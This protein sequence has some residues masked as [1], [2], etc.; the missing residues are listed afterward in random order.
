MTAAPPDAAPAP[1]GTPHPSPDAAPATRQQLLLAIP[2]LVVGAV[3]A[4]I[5]FGLDELSEWLEGLIWHAFPAATGLDPSNGFFIFTVLTLTGIA[6]GLVV[7]QLPGH[8]GR[9]SATTEL[10]APPLPLRSLPTLALVATLGLAGGVSLGPENPII[11]INAGLMAA[12]VGRMFKRVPVQLTVMMAAAGTVGAL[13]GTPVAAALVLTGIVAAFPRGGALWD[14]LFLPLVAAGAGSVTMRLLAKPTFELP[15]PAYDTIAPIDLLS[16]AG[17]AVAAAVFGVLCVVLFRALHRLFH[18][19]GNPLVYITLGG[20]VL[21][22]LGALGGEVTLFKGLAQMGELIAN[23]GEYSGLQLLSIFGVKL[24]AL[25]V[26]GASGFRGGHIFPAVFLGVA[27]GMYANVL[28]PAIPLTLAVGAGVLG[29]VLA[30]A[31]DGWIALFVATLITG[32]V[33]ALPLL[34]IAI[35]P[36]WLLVSRAPEM[37]VAEV[38]DTN[39][40]HNPFRR[41]PGVRPPAGQGSAGSGLDVR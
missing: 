8:G 7:W 38:P 31:R 12:V 36:A 33:V 41:R 23:S 25:A 26:A 1:G 16:G 17:I 30:I 15:L 19:L 6:V 2:A 4:L 10:I 39:R 37:V 40:V 14:R 11:A 27:F 32:S 35:L 22:L 29:M 24:I 3:S 28:I 9:D 13:F 20:M 18:G 21:G 34:C 5:L